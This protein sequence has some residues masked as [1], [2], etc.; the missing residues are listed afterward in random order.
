MDLSALR[1]VLDL[2][3]PNISLISAVF[4]SIAFSLKNC[5]PLMEWKGL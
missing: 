4:M 1:V 3:F 2:E 5:S